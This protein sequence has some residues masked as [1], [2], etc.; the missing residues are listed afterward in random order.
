MQFYNELIQNIETNSYL[1]L[2]TNIKLTIGCEG[3]DY[4]SMQLDNITLKYPTIK[5]NE[6]T[7]LD[8]DGKGTKAVLKYKE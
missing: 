1:D 2:G 8:I 7:N 6:I 3:I 5:V 4:F